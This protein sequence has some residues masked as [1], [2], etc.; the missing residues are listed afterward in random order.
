ITE[1]LK[2][3][4]FRSYDNC[5]DDLN[6]LKDLLN[7]EHIDLRINKFSGSLKVFQSFKKLK[8]LFISDNSFD[9][10]GLGYLPK[11]L[12]S[13]IVFPQE[14]FSLIL[15]Q[16]D[17]TNEEIK[18]LDGV[19]REF[20]G[21]GKLPRNGLV[22]FAL[23]ILAI[24]PLASLLNLATKEICDQKGGSVAGIIGAAFGN[25]IELIISIFV[26]IHGEIVVV[27][28]SML[29]SIIS[30]LLLVLGTYEIV[31]EQLHFKIENP[32]FP[33][34]FSIRLLVI[35]TVCVALTSDC[36]VSSIEEAAKTIKINK[37]FVAL[38]ILPNAGNATEVLI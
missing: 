26:L 15:A 4:Q 1:C 36:L 2:V 20:W 17:F 24:I 14:V 27:Q 11:S 34:S 32:L 13:L 16:K 31:I 10:G 29:G 8:N 35:V 30:N 12:K 19:S 18:R 25:V 28:A 7:L 38:I 22:T 6:V 3:E 5:L 21:L 33:L 23:N 37:F 9:E